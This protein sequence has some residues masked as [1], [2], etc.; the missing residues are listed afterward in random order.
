MT[1]ARKSNSLA[2]DGM[3]SLALM[4]FPALNPWNWWAL[5]APQN[6]MLA[7]MHTAQAMLQA[8]RNSADGM[9]AL[10]RVQQDTLLSMLEAP[11]H[12][13]GEGEAAEAE[14]PAN[15]VEKSGESQASLFVAPMLEATRAYGRVGKA[16]IVAQRDSLRAFAPAQRTAERQSAS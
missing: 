3:A 2:G 14:A 6:S 16:F 11:L 15:G 10:M 8:Y 5:A 7:S 13:S 9:R 12:T 4:P 1:R